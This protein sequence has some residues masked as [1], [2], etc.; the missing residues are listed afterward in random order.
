MTRASPP[1][2]AIRR[3]L[4]LLWGGGLALC[5]LPV[6]FAFALQI[7]LA[8]R[9]QRFDR[10]LPARLVWGIAGGAAAAWLLGI[11]MTDRSLGPTLDRLHETAEGAASLELPDERGPR[12]RSVHLTSAFGQMAARLQEA[13][14]KLQ[15]Q[16]DRLER[17]NAE[18][19]GAR[20]E[21]LRSER[22]ATIGRLAAGIGHEIGNPLGALLGFVDLGAQ[23]PAEVLPSIRTE[24]LRI[25]RTLQELMDFARPG[26]MELAPTSLERAFEAAF[27]LVRAHPKWR[28]MRTTLEFVPNLPPV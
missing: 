24:A 2:R 16:I 23:T 18:L 7:D 21:V 11:F 5:L 27:R 1:R 13:N 15:G 4:A 25:H 6:A 14:A 3:R 8:F 28:S 26:K 19:E 9:H 17:L 10:A 20:A 12:L 22:L